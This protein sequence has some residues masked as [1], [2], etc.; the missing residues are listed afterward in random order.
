M[1]QVHRGD[2]ALAHD[3]LQ[4]RRLAEMV[5]GAQGLH[6][7]ADGGAVEFGHLGQVEVG[8]PVEVVA[9]DRPGQCL[10]QPLVQAV[11]KGGEMV[12]AAVADTLGLDADLL[13][14]LL[15]ALLPAVDDADVGGAQVRRNLQVDV[16]IERRGEAV[17]V[18]PL[19]EY[20]VILPLQRLELADE[21][22]VEFAALVVGEHHLHF[23]DPVAVGLAVLHLQAEMF[24]HE[25][26]VPVPGLPVFDDG[27]E[28]GDAADPAVKKLHHSDGHEE[29][30]GLGFEGC[31]IET[32]CFHASIV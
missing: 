27:A 24:Q 10:H 15:D 16:E 19:T 26:D 9:A 30:S 8:H 4:V 23:G 11:D 12:A 13:A 6:H 14:Q 5:A 18:E 25:I 1:L 3:P 29:G 31:D 28:E 2:L 21:P 22:R 17:A 32:L 20:E 7:L